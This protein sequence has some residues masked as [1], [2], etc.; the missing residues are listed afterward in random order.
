VNTAKSPLRSN[1]HALKSAHFVLSAVPSVHHSKSLV[2]ESIVTAYSLGNVLLM[3][4][5]KRLLKRAVHR[6]AVKRVCR[7]AWLQTC[8]TTEC[9]EIRQM[10]AKPKLVKLVNL[11]KFGSTMALK[12]L[13]RADV[14]NLFAQLK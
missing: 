7:E 11:P 13:M 3:A 9:L 1:K 5:P 6:N 8:K 2:P 4:I 14:D 10:T 12:R